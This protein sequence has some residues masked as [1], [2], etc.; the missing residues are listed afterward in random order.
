MNDPIQSLIRGY[1]DGSITPSQFEQLQQALREDSAVREQL[2]HE[3]NV[4]ATL[5]DLATGTDSGK[6]SRGG[7]ESGGVDDSKDTQQDTDRRWLWWSYHRLAVAATVL[8]AVGALSFFAGRGN[9]NTEPASPRP[10]TVEG[11][12]RL[13]STVDARW[14]TTE[15][16][17]GKS[18]DLGEY[19]LVAG[20]VELEFREG[21]RV[22]LRG[23]AKF[24][25]RSSNHIHLTTGSLVANVPEEALGFTVTTPQSEVVDLGTEFG[26]AVDETG[27]TDIHVLDGLV[28]AFPRQATDAV[29]IS[30]G[31]ARRIDPA[32]D[33]RPQTI[34]VASRDALLGNLPLDPLGVELLRGVVR[35]RDSSSPIDLQERPAGQHWIDV[36]PEKRGVTLAQPI[37]VSIDRAGVYRRFGTSRQSIS[38]GTRVNSYLFHFRPENYER[39]HGVVR[40]AQPIVGVVC[41]REGLRATD[42][43]LGLPRV[44]YKV[45][46][47][48]WRGLE[49]SDQDHYVEGHQYIDEVTL[50]QDRRTLSLRI[51]ANP[52]GGVDQVRV[53]TRSDE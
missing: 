7:S 22:T 38:A 8:L 12:A 48:R 36:I 43:S 25:L 47:G 5:D 2:L 3:L 40:F 35:L 29:M 50:S 44:N 11:V 41:I 18:L 21:A 1:A 14:Q 9:W 33:S 39:V 34:P 45:K 16:L 51:N 31:E 49:S 19:R 27:R 42:E 17:P 26:L 30:Q 20:S 28:Q 37:E 4:H 6:A 15:P 13:I 24:A 46:A 52:S 10:R 53:L 23:P 32:D